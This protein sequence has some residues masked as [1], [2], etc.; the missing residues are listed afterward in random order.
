ML[1]KASSRSGAIALANHLMNDRENDH[2]MLHSLRGFIADDLHGALRE[3]YAM[4]RA[5]RCKAF[6][7]SVSVNPPQ[8]QS[9]SDADLEAAIDRIEGKIGLNGFQRAI[10]VHEKQGRRHA[11]AVWSRID[12]NRMRAINLP[13]FKR[14]LMDVSRELY[15]EHGW[16]LPDGYKKNGER[17]PLNFTLAEWQQAKRAKVDPRDVKRDLQECWA[18]SDDARSF[19]RALE[20]RGY[21]L[22]KGDRRS[23]VAVDWRGEIYAIARWTGQKTKD[24]RARLGDADALPGIEQAREQVNDRLGT[25]LI[26]LR[27]SQDAK[28]SADETVFAERRKALVMRQRHERAELKATQEAARTAS[29]IARQAR[30]PRGLKAIWWRVTG[31]LAIERSRM[32]AE[33]KAEI[34]TH[35]HIRQQ[36]IDA[37]L[38]E[39]RQLQTERRQTSKEHDN[40]SLTLTIELEFLKNSPRT[41]DDRSP[42]DDGG[43]KRRRQRNRS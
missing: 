13:H 16:D 2:V 32:E 22:A 34:D 35:G 31:K 11:H 19:S 9:V 25:R 42:D 38:A 27:K 24:V 14:K 6:L 41:P 8:N 5:T 36:L 26:D 40:T 39:R 29:A 4:S 10:V 33:A 23:H 15:I 3:A 20:G 12:L 30:L 18:R 28:R 1:L 21:I 37:Q 17:N 43:Q 7:F